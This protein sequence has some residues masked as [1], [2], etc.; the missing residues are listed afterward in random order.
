MDLQR[1]LYLIL[2]SEKFQQVRIK[3]LLAT[4][5]TFKGHIVHS[6][7]ICSSQ[8]WPKPMKM[9][10]HFR[11]WSIRQNGYLVGHV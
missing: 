9:I 11:Y 6:V 3:I 7:F 2:M 10:A 1:A 8:N 5:F 4:D